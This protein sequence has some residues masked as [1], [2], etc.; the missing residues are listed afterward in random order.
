M[1]FSTIYIYIFYTTSKT[2]LCGTSAVAHSTVLPS[3]LQHINQETNV[4]TPPAPS[5]QQQQQQQQRGSWEKEWEIAQTKQFWVKWFLNTSAP[6]CFLS[7]HLQLTSTTTHTTTKA[8]Y[9]NTAIVYVQMFCQEVQILKNQV[10][11]ILP[12]LTYFHIHLYLIT[13]WSTGMGDTGHSTL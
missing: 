12:N 9:S 10:V 5:L 8:K 2:L 6:S 3:P 13:K 4:E 7:T 1:I 11:S